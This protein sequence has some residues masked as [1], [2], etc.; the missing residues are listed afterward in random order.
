VRLRVNGEV[1]DVPFADF[2][3]W[4]IFKIPACIAWREHVYHAMA[5]DGIVGTRNIL[6]HQYFGIDLEKVWG[7]VQVDLPP[8]KEAVE[9]LIERLK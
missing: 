4:P 5:H 1:V 8:L 7:M 2:W 3:D 9:S 6:I